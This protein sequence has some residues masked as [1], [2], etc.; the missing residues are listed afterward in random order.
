MDP[1]VTEFDNSTRF[2]VGANSARAY[3]LPV[4]YGGGIDINF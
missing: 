4:F 1:E 2:N 3:F